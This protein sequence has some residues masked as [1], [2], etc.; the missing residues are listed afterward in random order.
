MNYDIQQLLGIAFATARYSYRRNDSEI[1]SEAQYAMLLALRSYDAEK[2][3]L[4][5]WV[6]YN[7]ER[8]LQSYYRKTYSHT[9][10]PKILDRI[11]DSRRNRASLYEAV[12]A[13]PAIDRELAEQHFI[14]G[15]SI[16]QIAT[17]KQ[18]SILEIRVAVDRV[19]RTLRQY[20][21]C[22]DN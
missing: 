15:F 8:R 14:A 1:M 11:V 21:Y 12:D 3:E 2:G 17:N 10:D 16:K 5:P 13:L 22:E 19:R 6:R 18:K 7:V 20:I 4:V 9:I